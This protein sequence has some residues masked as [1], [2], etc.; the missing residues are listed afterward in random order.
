MKPGRV[1]RTG[2]QR[3]LASEDTDRSAGERSEP[4]DGVQKLLTGSLLGLMPC[5]P[6]RVG[7]GPLVRESP[8]PWGGPE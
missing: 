7:T 4:L 3:A 6:G 2:P 5:G 1:A 8:R